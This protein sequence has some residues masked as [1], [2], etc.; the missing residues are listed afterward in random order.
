ML[1]AN[2]TPPSMRD[3]ASKAVEQID[4]VG[5]VVSAAPGSYD[6]RVG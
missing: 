6:G 1:L 3:G 4:T 2:G 5:L